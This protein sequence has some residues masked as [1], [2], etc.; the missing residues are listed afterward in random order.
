MI[1]GD[2]RGLPQGLPA[3]LFCRFGTQ[4]H[5]ATRDA[6]RMKPPIV[7]FSDGCT[8]IIVTVIRGADKKRPVTGKFV[9]E[10]A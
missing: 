10:D 1:R 4:N 2:C 7:R 6:V 5:M 3:W 8:E 9:P